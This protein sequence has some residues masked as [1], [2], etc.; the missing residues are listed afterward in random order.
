MRKDFIKGIEYNISKYK[1]YWSKD[2]YFDALTYLGEVYYYIHDNTTLEKQYGEILKTV[3]ITEYVLKKIKIEAEKEK[4]NLQNILNFPNHCVYE[5]IVLIFTNRMS[6]FL[7]ISFLKKEIGIDIELNLTDIDELICE[8]NKYKKN[9]IPFRQ[10]LDRIKTCYNYS[11]E[12]IDFLSN[13][14]KCKSGMLV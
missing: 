5:E 7:V 8:L 2:L 9:R 6:L 12:L 11:P 4:E 1:E 14:S 13:F 10:G 3:S